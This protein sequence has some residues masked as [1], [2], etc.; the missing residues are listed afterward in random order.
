MTTHKIR[1]YQNAADL[2]LLQ[3]VLKALPTDHPM[4]LKVESVLF[5]NKEEDEERAINAAWVIYDHYMTTAAGV[6]ATLLQ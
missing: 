1:L 6:P 5:S 2:R 4:R 3:C